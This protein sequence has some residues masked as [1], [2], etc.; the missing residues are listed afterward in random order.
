VYFVAYKRIKKY[1]DARKDY[2]ERNIR[3]AEQAKRLHEGKAKEADAVIEEANKEALEIIAKAKLDA[4]SSAE[5]I[6]EEADKE[7]A[8]RLI[9]ADEEIKKN[10]EKARAEL[11]DEIVEIALE[12][13]RQVL[14]REVNEEDNRQLVDDFAKQ[15]AKKGKK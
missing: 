10:E 12:A 14:G 7:A 13:S 9:H 8:E 6:I 1:K 11:H 4:S 5:K 2:I 15:I 3:D